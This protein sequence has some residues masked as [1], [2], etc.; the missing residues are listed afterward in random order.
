MDV[1]LSPGGKTSFVTANPVDTVLVGTIDGVHR[2]SRNAANSAWTVSRRGLDGVHVGSLLSIP[3]G[4]L[5]AG[6]HSGGLFRSD[7]A[8][9]PWERTMDGIAD[10]HSQVY[11]L[12][13]QQR[14]GRLVLWAGTQPA[15]L[16]RS[17]DLGDTWTELPGIRDVPDTDKWT[18]PAPPHVAHVKN[19][20]FHPTDASTMYVCIE[21]G[22]L[23][24]SVDDGQTWHELASYSRADDIAYRD[25]HRLVIA[26]THP[27]KLF[28]TSGEGVYTSDDAGVTWTHL[29]RKRDRLGYPDQLFIDPADESTIYVAGAA[30]APP[31]WRE[32]RDGNPGVLKS[33]DGGRTWRELSAG[34]PAKIRGNIEAMTLA[35][36][37]HGIEF[38]AGTALGD[39]FASANGGDSWQTIASGLPAVSKAGHYRQFVEA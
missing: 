29:T 32:K 39:V 24:K 20:A 12:A 21:Q 15:A 26:P 23:L 36:G 31:N 18:F 4:R 35:S 28:M 22:A 14:D 19:I 7:D 25:A 9:A 11:C 10:A 33:T 5:F 30:N 3:G 37:A 8:T 1:C 13:A 27:D 34:L 17:D 38:F 16:Y 2:L 6:A